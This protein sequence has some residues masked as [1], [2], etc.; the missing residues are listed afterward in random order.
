LF[1]QGGFLSYIL[2]ES[3]LNI[4]F[5]KDIR[6]F[7]L[8]NAKAIKIFNYNRIFSNVFTPVI[9]LDLQKIPEHNISLPIITNGDSYTINS[10]RFQRNKDL[11]FDI[12]NTNEDAR[13]IEKVYSLE[14]QT[15]QNQA[16]WVLGI[17]SGNNKEFLAQSPKKG[18]Q[19]ILKGTDI[20]KFQIKNAKN[21]IRFDRDKLQQAAPLIRYK[22]KEKLIYKF[23]SNKLVF[24]YDNKQRL[25]LNSA[26][27][28][29]PKIPDYSIKAIMALF[30]S[31]LYQFIFK[32]K[33][34]AL[35]VLRS[36]LEQL[37]LPLFETQ[38]LERL[39]KFSDQL[40]LASADEELYEERFAE[41][42]EM[43]FNLFGLTNAEIKRIQTE[44]T[45]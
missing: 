33:F 32:K 26:N 12:Y 2:P 16:D 44:V 21:W 29:I 13:I 20:Q 23:I 24:A 27:I 30:N 31:T 22:A 39:E 34:F 10:S 3:I 11:V 7:I 5:H 45:K 8:Q 43:V 18:W 25:S 28:V 17:V 40:M 36:H 9:R 4:K 41:L 35:K 37:P 6:Q 14:H 42:D 19:V 15:L 38:T 1:N